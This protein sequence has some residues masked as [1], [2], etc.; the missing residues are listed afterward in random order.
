MTSFARL[1]VLLFLSGCTALAIQNFDKQY[2]LSKPQQ[3][4]VASKTAAGQHYFDEVRP[5]IEHRCVVCHACYDAP[6]QLKMTSPAGI[7]RGAAKKRVYNAARLTATTPT[8]LHI[9]RSTTAGW[10]EHGFDAVLNE[11]EQTPEANLDA[12]VMARLLM[13]KQEHPLP[14]ESPLPKSFK[15][16]L[17]A[18]HECPRIEG[19]QQYEAN[20]PL[21]GMPYGLPAL[22]SSEHELLMA[23]IEGGAKM[24]VPNLGAEYLDRVAEWET[25]LNGDDNKTRLVARYIYEH[26]F[27]ADLYF[28]DM[29]EKRY[30]RLVRSRSAPGQP[31]D[32]IA[33]RRP[34][35]NPKVDRV[36]YRLQAAQDTVLAKS[37]MPYS[38]GAA[39]MDWIKSLFFNGD[40]SVV[41]LPDYQPQLA[42]NPFLTFAALPL[43]ARYRFMLEEA[44]FTISGYIKGS[45]CRGQVALDVINDHFW[46]VFTDPDSPTLAKQDQFLLDQAQNLRMPG[47]ADSNG[48]PL[49]HWIRLAQAQRKFLTAKSEALSKVFSNGASLDTQLIWDGDGRNDNAALT[50]FRHFDSATVIKG[51]QG[52][53]PKTAWLIDYS[54]LERIHYLLVTEFDVYG[55]LGHQLNTR[56]YMDFLRMEGEFNF[57]TLLPSEDRIRHRDFWYR[58]AQR[59]VKEHI[60]GCRAVFDQPSGID[61]VTNDPKQELFNLL[62]NRLEP[63]M[64]NKHALHN[65]SVPASHQQ[66]LAAINEMRGSRVTVLPETALLMVSAANGQSSLYTVLRN[67]AHY[68]ITS[69]FLEKK[70]RAYEEDYMTVLEGVVSAY[71]D[72]FWRVEESQ[73]AAMVKALNEVSEE[74]DYLDFLSRYGVRR[75]SPDF[76]QH[77]DAVHAAYKRIDAKRAGILDYNRLE[78]R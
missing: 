65:A 58:K 57:L 49:F 7:D 29:P 66:A 13:L 20:K 25:F 76:W 35:D 41:E 63:A 22:S 5:V 72:A 33:T 62:Q 68:N 75:T 9:D 32:I 26:L 69:V 31:L 59:R 12:S 60:L 42:S 56:R 16:S 15:F 55:N 47:E 24:S 11:R 45:V 28:D 6:C 3:R 8:R 46:V 53:E 14:S 10:R 52:Q 44:H 50:I 78:N 23:W 38:F 40:Y 17:N 4:L 2:G 34:N 18:K 39:R 1:F 67:S 21:A 61:Y 74:Q 77:S 54:L 70:N 36:Y 51:F 37:H 27:R 73:L 64:S 19:M 30:F 48:D 43:K 71:P